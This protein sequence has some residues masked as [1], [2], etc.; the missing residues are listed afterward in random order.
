MRRS[1]FNRILIFVILIIY[2][3]AKIPI[4]LIYLLGMSATKTKENI[5]L[6]AIGWTLAMIIIYSI[7]FIS[8]AIYF[9]PVFFVNFALL[10]VPLKIVFFALI[11]HAVINSA[12][13]IRL[14]QKE[15]ELIKKIISEHKIILLIAMV[16][17][18]VD[19]TILLVLSS[20]LYAFHTVGLIFP[21][22]W[23]FAEEWLISHRY[24]YLVPGN[25][26][27]WVL[28]KGLGLGTQPEKEIMPYYLPGFDSL[29]GRVKKVQWTYL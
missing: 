23:Y 18:Y 3:N 5:F 27:A 10:G 19:I 8:S 13:A 26:I 2:R 17:A 25:I 28:I 9:L 7:G 16:S 29:V 1:V 21:L 20:K 15:R 4:I 24:W 6:Y 14:P 22:I 11:G 12:T